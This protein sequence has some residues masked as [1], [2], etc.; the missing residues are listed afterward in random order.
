MIRFAANISTIFHNK[1]LEYSIN[2]VAEAGLE[3]FEFWFARFYDVDKM[4]S[5]RKQHNLKVV[6][7]D[8]DIGDFSMAT[9][10]YLATPEKEEEFFKSLKEGLALARILGCGK[11]VAMSGKSK[12]KVL[13]E[14]QK[15]M[16]V[17]RL[18]DACPLLRRNKVTL[19]IEPLNKYEN[20]DYFL[21]SSTAGFQI[22]EEV[23]S[24][25]VKLLY[26]TYH[27][28]LAEGNL[29]NTISKNIDKIGHLQF[30]DVPNRHEPGTGEINFLS[31][32]RTLNDIGYDGYVGLEYF[33]IGG[34]PFQ[35]IQEQKGT[36]HD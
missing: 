12:K 29:V 26:D 6:L 7:F 11:L 32:I 28:Q 1:P 35:W 17:D 31:L 30:G 33:P 23:G 21:T 34:H 22:V 14:I 19:L 5:L 36:W 8:L 13:P 18:K 20:P 16:I 15:K 25:Y 10:G 4:N 27:M 2:K 3:G 9:W 24:S